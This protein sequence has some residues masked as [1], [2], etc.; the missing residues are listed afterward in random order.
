MNPHLKHGLSTWAFILFVTLTFAYSL[1]GVALTP[2]KLGI[3]LLICLAMGA[4]WGAGANLL[5][6]RKSA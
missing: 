4:L 2:G 5:A 1:Q 3:T 6:K